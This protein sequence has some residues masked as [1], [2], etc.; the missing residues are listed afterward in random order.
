MESSKNTFPTKAIF[1]TSHN[2]K[3][4]A[5]HKGRHYLVKYLFDNEADKNN[6]GC[7]DG[8]YDDKFHDFLI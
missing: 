6:D 3:S 5:F 4:V 2:L 7:D 8:A 1:A